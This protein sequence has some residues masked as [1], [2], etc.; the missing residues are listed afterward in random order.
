MSAPY[1]RDPKSQRR[2]N[3]NKQVH[4]AEDIY[5]FWENIRLGMR[6]QF[7]KILVVHLLLSTF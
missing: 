7:M 2:E 5:V 4:L 1:L 3:G 6:Q